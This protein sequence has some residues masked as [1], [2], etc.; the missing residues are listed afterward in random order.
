MADQL[1]QLTPE[2]RHQ[3]MLAAQQQA[4][5]QIMQGMITKMSKS[6]FDKCA[7]TSVRVSLTLLRPRESGV[8][9]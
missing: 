8:M 7:G 4:N 6:C 5:E 9:L 2:N 1:A 3:L